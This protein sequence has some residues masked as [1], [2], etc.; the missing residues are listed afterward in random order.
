MDPGACR[1]NKECMIFAN[2]KVVGEERPILDSQGFDPHY[3]QRVALTG[4]HPD[5]TGSACRRT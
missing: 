2:L 4:D 5:D 3:L 1:A